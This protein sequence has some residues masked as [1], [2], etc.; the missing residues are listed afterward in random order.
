MRSLGCVRG[1]GIVAA[2]WGLLLCSGCA[3]VPP[4]HVG[5]TVGAI[6]GSAIVP[7]LGAPLGSLVG[8]LGGMLVQGKIDQVTEK[9]ERKALSEQLATGPTA[10]PEASPAQMGAPTR[11]WVDETMQGGRLIAGHFETRAIP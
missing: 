8:L 10:G 2:G 3:S 9:R 5:Q 7:G 11:V 1:A 6:V 4:A